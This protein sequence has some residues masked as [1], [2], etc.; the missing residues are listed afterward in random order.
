MKLLRLFGLLSPGGGFLF[1]V[2]KRFREP[3]T[4]HIDL[5]TGILDRTLHVYQVFRASQFLAIRRSRE[6]PSQI[7]HFDALLLGRFESR[8]GLVAAQ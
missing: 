8:T 2:T 5:L 4:G 7:V 1:H 6:N 3:R